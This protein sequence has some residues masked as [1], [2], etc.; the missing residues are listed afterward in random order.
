MLLVRDGQ[1]VDAYGATERTLGVDPE[2]AVGLLLHEVVATTEPARLDEVF[3]H[4]LGQRDHGAKVTGLALCEQ[5]R[6]NGDGRYVDVAV[7][8][9]SH[10]RSVRAY[11]V[12]VTDATDR[13]QAQRA[14]AV[15]ASVDGETLLPN[16]ERLVELLDMTL[17]RARRK[18]DHVAV[19]TVGIDRHG[20]IVEGFDESA[21]RAIMTEIA[22]RVRSTVRLEDPVGRV[23]KDQFAV[24]LGGLEPRI[25]RAFALDVADRISRSV[26]DP[27]EV[28]GSRLAMA[29]SVGAAHRAQG[30][31]EPSP[32]ELL[33]EAEESL[34]QVRANTNRWKDTT[35]A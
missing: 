31:P 19:L 5:N 4:A 24:I 7:R 16:R 2:A 27:F 29:V 13:T 28:S 33:S 25:G 30:S 10:D 15:A 35:P 17:H 14:L 11:V 34:S 23:S 18:G 8:D 22:R 9:K 21:Q 1:V 26:G 6:A 20:S 12:T 32:H 3:N